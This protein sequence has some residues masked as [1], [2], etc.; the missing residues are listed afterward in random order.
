M[1]A[2]SSYD[3]IIEFEMSR[4]PIEPDQIIVTIDGRVSPPSDW[5]Y[6]GTAGNKIVFDRAAAPTGEDVVQIE[7]DYLVCR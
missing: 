6:D 2:E 3:P 5:E 7:Y 4:T 1:I